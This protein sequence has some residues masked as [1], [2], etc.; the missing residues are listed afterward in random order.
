MNITVAKQKSNKICN[1]FLLKC[2]HVPRKWSCRYKIQQMRQ[3]NE[4][5]TQTTPKKQQ[6]RAPITSE[7][8]ACNWDVLWSCSVGGSVGSTEHVCIC[9]CL[10][11]LG[12][13]VFSP[14]LFSVCVVSIV[15]H[16]STGH[17]R[18]AETD[19]K[20]YIE[21][22]FWRPVARCILSAIIAANSNSAA[23]YSN[24]TRVSSVFDG[25]LVLSWH[26]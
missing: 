24:G 20:R 7:A 10:V 2:V 8:L 19:R 3:Q 23:R 16:T 14:M 12:V 13:C 9:L 18:S 21:C 6:H 17:C 11:S 22:S 25:Y 1:T 26:V 5:Q 4:R 15:N